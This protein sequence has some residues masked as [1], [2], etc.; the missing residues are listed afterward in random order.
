VPGGG[1]GQGLAGREILVAE[2]EPA[3]AELTRRYLEKE[4]L[5]VRCA[6]TPEDT[7][8]ALAVCQ[9]AAVVL[10]LTMPGLDARQIR[11]L[12]RTPPPGRR[13][14]GSQPALAG[15]VPGAT[16]PVIC[17][18]AGEGAQAAQ[19]LRPRDIG[20]SQESCLPRPFGPRA[21]VARVRAAARASQAPAPAATPCGLHLDPAARLVRRDGA[22]IRLT[23]T[24]FDLLACLAREAGRT[25]SR[26]RLRREIWAAGAAP[27]GR[28][29]DVYVAQLRVKLG[30]G[31]GIRTVRGVGYVLDVPA[32]VP[33]TSTGPRPALRDT[34]AGP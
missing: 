20:V 4:G 25:Q 30:P 33:A 15:P 19:A 31:S 12:I 32:P 18:T 23:G 11:R 24:E 13:R 1:N 29:V 6:R 7:V 10:D 8:A 16:V 9:A 22:A 27:A 17:L 34:A 14:A 26:D 2:H 3:V 21:L 5:S 28:I